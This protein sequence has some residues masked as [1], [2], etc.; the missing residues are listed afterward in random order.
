MNVTELTRQMVA[1]CSH[2]WSAPFTTK[3]DFAREYADAVAAAASLGMIT[4]CLRQGEYSRH[5]HVTPLGI[6]FINNME[7]IEC[8]FSPSIPPPS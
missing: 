1:V 4:T 6:Q 3:S 5:W 8:S 2:A 7:N